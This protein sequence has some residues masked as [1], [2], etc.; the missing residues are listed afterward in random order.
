MQ[1]ANRGGQTD[2]ATEIAGEATVES[3]PAERDSSDGENG[4][5]ANAESGAQL[6]GS[7]HEID[8]PPGSANSPAPTS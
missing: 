1:K 4:I 6:P 7:V 8:A 3:A 5:D 2:M